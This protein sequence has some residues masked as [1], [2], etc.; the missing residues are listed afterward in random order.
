MTRAKAQRPTVKATGKR[1]PVWSIEYREY[2]LVD[3]EERS[4]HKS[5]S[6]LR[7]LFTK[8]AAQREADKFMIALE[9]GGPRPDGSMTLATFW[10]DVYLPIR[11]RRWTGATEVNVLSVWRNHIAPALGKM[12]LKDITKAAIQ[13]HLGKLVDKGLGRSA[14][15]SVRV[16]LSSV[17]AEAADNDYIPKNPCRKVETPNCGPV[18][19]ARSLTEA[20]VRKLWD[21]TAGRDYLVWR[22]LIL[23][24]ARIGELLALERA[25]VLP[26]DALP[27]TGLRID[28]TRVGTQIK[29][30]K[31]NKVRVAKLPTSL[32]A[33]IEEWIAMHDHRLLFPSGAGQVYYRGSDSI[34]AI[35][36][37]GRKIV[38]GL[39]FRQ[40]RTTFAS[41]FDG[42]A[43][44][45]TSIMGHTSE[46]FTLERY[47]KPI[48][49][50]AQQ[51]VE[52]MDLR[53][54]V[55]KGKK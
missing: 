31:R 32:R 40:C 51:S 19:E 35:V 3:G 41:L 52:K 20:E 17:L 47:R 29:L 13:L 49:E 25:D 38:P 43:A 28:E 18:A 23:T 8:S 39:T 24:G 10:E 4:R 55:V 26:L 16:R 30:P 22:I 5:K 9:Q 46:K 44:D 53:L 15:D 12:K 6:W 11:K 33:E 7:S 36:E 27:E 45:R 1:I 48:Q 37:R 34:Q 54:T 21:E 2:Y 14:V 50:R 42:D